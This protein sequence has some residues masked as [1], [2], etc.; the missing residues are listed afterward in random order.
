MPYPNDKLLQPGRV[1]VSV[2]LDGCH[3]YPNDKLLQLEK[4]SI[5]GYVEGCHTYPNDK[6]LQRHFR[7]QKLLD[8]ELSYLSKR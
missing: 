1:H 8:L 4:G 2:E 7:V 3:T 6:L 5:P